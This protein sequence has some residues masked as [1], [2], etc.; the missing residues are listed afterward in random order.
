MMK[1]KSMPLFLIC[2][3]LIYLLK[4]LFS[5][6]WLFFWFLCAF[7]LDDIFLV[8]KYLHC[9]SF[10]GK[11]RYFDWL[12]YKMCEP[13]GVKKN[14]CVY[15][16]VHLIKFLSFFL[17]LFIFLTS[18]NPLKE[19]FKTFLTIMLWLYEEIGCFYWVA[20]WNKFVTAKWRYAEFFFQI[21]IHRKVVSL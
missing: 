3:L 10:E 4:Y 14:V 17:S 20:G 6:F 18:K 13:S 15:F 9:K 12:T 2:Y 19:Y 1:K 8:W 11:I 5:L 7:P 16:F 21:V